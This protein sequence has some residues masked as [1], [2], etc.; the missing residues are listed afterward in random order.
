MFTLDTHAPSAKHFLVKPC[1]R[2]EL[3]S[4]HSEFQKHYSIMSV[5][6]NYQL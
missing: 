2:K 3:G 4:A 6:F 5:G 1:L